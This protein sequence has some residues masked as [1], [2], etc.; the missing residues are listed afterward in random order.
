MDGFFF[1][2]IYRMFVE[3][4]PYFGKRFLRFNQE[5]LYPKLHRYRDNAIISCK[6]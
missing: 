2:L 4:C 1:L 5:H 6:Q 3:E